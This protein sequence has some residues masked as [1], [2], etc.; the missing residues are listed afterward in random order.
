MAK[1][2]S[3]DALR[4]LKPQLKPGE[5]VA[6]VCA[7]CGAPFGARGDLLAHEAQCPVGKKG[8]KAKRLAGVWPGFAATPLPQ[9]AEQEEAGPG[10]AGPGAV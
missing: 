5:T 6:G 9:S 10:P 4:R 7:R 3:G 1:T 2:L 8:P